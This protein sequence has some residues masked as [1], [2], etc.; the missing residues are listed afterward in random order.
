MELDRVDVEILRSLQADARLSFRDLA[1]RVGVSVPTI[2][3]RVTNLEQLGILAGYHATVDPERL[4]QVRVVLIITCGR[5]AADAVGTALADLREVRWSVRTEDDRVVGEAVL[6]DATGVE[7]LVWR[8][9]GIEG[10]RDVAHDV[11]ARA[12]KDAPRAVIAPGV[13]AL[14]R[15][16]ECGKVIEGEPVR[17]RA[18]GRVHYLCCPSCEKLYR[19]R[20]GRIRA[21]ARPVRHR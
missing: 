14:L 21:E 2:S 17:W 20:Y 5:G 11:A 18:D 1:R 3:A 8:V 10:V 16:F 12:Y 4:G 15:C 6:E 7:P 13:A 9:R 19:A